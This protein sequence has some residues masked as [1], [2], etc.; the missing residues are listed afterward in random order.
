MSER[1]KRPEGLGPG[2]QHDTRYVRDERPLPCEWAQETPLFKRYTDPLHHVRLP[3]PKM[4]GGA[5]LW[6]IIT[7]RHS[8][9]KFYDESLTRQDL[10]QL[11]WATQ[12]KTGEYGQRLLRAVASAGGLYPNE[13]YLVINDVE[14]L[15]PG[16]VHYDVRD[17]ALS[18]LKLGEF[19]AQCAEACLG[20][21][22][23]ATGQVVFAWSAVVNRCA[24]KYGDRAYRYIYLDAGHL[25]AQLQLAAVA[26][27]LGS[28]NI[29]AFLDDEVNTL[30]E[31][32]IDKEPVI[33]LTA[34]G[35]PT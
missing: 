25:G 5:G 7:E 12:G 11:L 24:Q 33:Y 23:C 6:S 4:A 3:E 28:V 2:Y 30:F 9:R 26:L 18:Y 16:I 15:D 20:Q 8:K 21:H 32:D 13:C 19:G 10:S 31:L 22:F 1:K 14:G 29:G 27:G 17:H 34:V 35:H